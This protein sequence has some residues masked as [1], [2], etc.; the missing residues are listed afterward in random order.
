MT[1]ILN[2]WSAAADVIDAR[3]WAQGVM[4]ADDGSVCLTGALRACSPQP[5]DWLI[6]RAVARHRD[7]A[8]NW[9]DS[10]ATTR[11][12][13]TEWLRTATSI[14]DAELSE[15]FGPQWEPIIDLIRRA[16][17][18]TSDEVEA[19]DVVM[20]AAWYGIWEVVMTSALGA[21]LVVSREDT[22]DASLLATR[23]AALA[24]VLPATRAAAGAA[25]R[26]ATG[27]LAVRDLIGQHGF[28]QEHYDT[29]TA[30]WATVIGKVH[31][32]D[33]DR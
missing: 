22:W 4:E 11:D 27:A 2:P 5:G 20:D 8:E 9:N 10:K 31:P 24:S 6:A 17:V 12:D 19:L 3:G 18:L 30:P 25:T 14:T 16:A 13:V 23:S 32:E 26:A 28:R 7:H 1:E 21:A 15:V 29:L 33:G